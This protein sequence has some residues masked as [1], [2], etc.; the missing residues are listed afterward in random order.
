MSIDAPFLNRR[1]LLQRTAAGFG[2]AAL[3]ALIGS[4]ARALST[5]AFPH[6]PAPL[7]KPCA[8]RVIF[9][10]MNG[11]P[12]H[13]DTFDPKPALAKFAGQQPTGELFKKSKG[14]GFMPS[15]L[16]FAK[17]GQSGI[18]VS[19]TLP[20]IARVIDDC[21][22]VRSMHTDVPNH[23]PALL[24]MHTGNVQ[25]IRP[26]LGS[27]L[28]YGLGSENENLP[29]Y[30]VLRPSNQIVVGPALWSNS[31]LPAQYQA[32][33]VN[34]SDMHVEKLLANIK[35]PALTRPQQRQQLDLL[36]QLNESHLKQ[37]DGDPQLEAQIQTMETAF[38]MQAEAMN[39]FDISREPQSVRDLYGDSPFARSCLLARRLV[40]DGVR[41]V[42]V[43]YTATG[44]QPWDTHTNHD[45]THPKLCRDSDQ[46]TAALIA[47][48]KARGM[49]EDTL[50]VWGGEFGRTP[51][52]E[53]KESA[54]AGR[55]H[56]HTAFS[57][58]LAGGGI[59]AG[60]AYGAS[61]DFGMVATEKPVHVHDLHATL[62]HLVGLDHE[63]LTYRYAGRDFRLTD[64]YGQVVKDICIA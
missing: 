47:D 51:Y 35:N 31:F 33:S 42:T 55:D 32:T 45:A 30:V 12:S 57:M 59:K 5:A 29:G 1:Q 52:A 44:T 34:T 49:L 3:A 7:F 36:G 38:R 4:P 61:D 8:K 21:C 26:S 50:V 62:L 25:P 2:S 48:L 53:N 17:Y 18:D 10:Y 58:L 28:V 43:Y 46:A 9:L 37:R 27:W 16:T 13:V 41:F 40:E 56:H 39:T 63:K 19:S 24:Q 6:V 11:G 54:K 22:I 15:P 60:Q 23:E 64:V 20:H 14:S